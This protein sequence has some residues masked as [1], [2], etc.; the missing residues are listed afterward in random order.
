MTYDSTQDTLDHMH[1][2]QARIQEIVHRLTIRAAHHDLSKL[3]DPEKSLLDALGSQTNLPPYGS[4]EERAR[5]DALSE[6]RKHH[7]AANDHH[8]EHTADGFRGMSLLSLTE[9]LCDWEAA[10][11]RHVSGGIQRSLEF[12]RK[13]FD[14]SDELFA[15]LENT[16]KELGW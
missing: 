12:N 8:P 11:A 13:R 1:K 4:P 3:A 7:Y 6:F 10:G 16:V 14:I 5:F 2:V 9:M 15:I